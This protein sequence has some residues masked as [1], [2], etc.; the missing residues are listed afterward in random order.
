MKKLKLKNK[1]AEGIF[2]MSFSMIFSILLIV[3]FI[4]V[5]FMVVRFFLKNQNCVQIGLFFDDFKKK[6]DIA[7]HSSGETKFS[8]NS[9]LPAG[10]EYVCLVNLTGE[11]N[12]DP[13]GQAI[14]EYIGR[15]SSVSYKNNLYLYSPSKKQ[16]ESFYK[17]DYVSLSDKNP[18]CFKVIKNKL[19]VSL[20]RTYSDPAVHVSQN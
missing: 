18:N 9:S 7:R 19:S 1:K 3:F 14:F 20:T 16:C 2:G 8:F 5:A 17:L 13:I 6:V 10:I 15:E 4:A 12:T 11:I